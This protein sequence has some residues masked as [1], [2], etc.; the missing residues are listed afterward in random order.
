LIINGIADSQKAAG[1][2]RKRVARFRGIVRTE[3]NVAPILTHRL[4]CS[5]KAARVERPSVSR[6]KRERR[7]SGI[8]QSRRLL[9]NADP[10]VVLL[11]E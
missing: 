8:T 3:P 2:C 7:Y 4:H 5:R 11:L 1:K 9:K 10:L 6:R